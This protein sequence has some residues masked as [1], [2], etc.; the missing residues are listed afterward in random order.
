MTNSEIESTTQ[1]N[2]GG[3]FEFLPT[4]SEW[5]YICRHWGWWIA[6]I[7]TG[8][9]VAVVVLLLSVPHYSQTD[10][11]LVRTD[12]STGISIT[13][14]SGDA[15]DALQSYNLSRSGGNLYD[16][17]YVIQSR[18]LI[19]QVIDSL[20]L[21]TTQY[22][23]HG[24]TWR[25]AY[26]QQAPLHIV[27]DR[28]AREHNFKMKVTIVSGEK[29]IVEGKLTDG[30]KQTWT[31]EV[32]N[33]HEIETPA[34]RIA[35][36]LA[37]S[38]AKV[39]GKTVRVVHKTK[40][41]TATEFNNKITASTTSKDTYLI[42]ITCVDES[43]ERARDVVE[44]ILNA[45]VSDVLQSKNLQ[46][47]KMED[48]I[49]V[50]LDSLS[51]QLNVVEAELAIFRSNHQVI[52][53]EASKQAFF[54]QKTS[55]ESQQRELMQEQQSVSRLRDWFDLNSDIDVMIPMLDGMEQG[56]LLSVNSYNTLLEQ[57]VKIYQPEA[58]ALSS[59]IVKNLATELGA[60]RRSIEAS[61]RNSYLALELQINT[62]RRQQQ[63]IEEQLAA[64]PTGTARY[65]VLQQQ[66]KVLEGLYMYDLNL[67]EEVWLQLSIDVNNLRKIETGI[68]RE[69]GINTHRVG[70]LALGGALGLLII[71]IW[72]L[73][74]TRY[75]RY[76]KEANEV[77]QLTTLPIVG[78]LPL[79]GPDDLDPTNE[80]HHAQAAKEAF[81][82]LRSNI[83]FVRNKGKCILVTA[84]S[85]RQG[86]TF[87]SLNLAQT[88]AS[89]SH[90]V[91]L[92]DGDIRKKTA[93]K[94]ILEQVQGAGFTD[95]LAGSVSDISTI[96]HKE[97]DR[98]AQFDFIAGGNTAPNPSELMTLPTLGA[99]LDWARE[100][101]DYVIIDSAPA[102]SVAD[103]L[104]L[105]QHTDITLFIV[106]VRMESRR[107][108]QN[109]HLLA[110]Q[111]D[112]RNVNIV[113]NA[114]NTQETYYSS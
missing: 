42:N 24:L 20:D 66:Q 9:A 87:V 23:R 17:L 110:K 79:C 36:V 74:R 62:L 80:S 12:G 31:A 63:R 104:L 86:K 61:V 47:H 67:R 11:L 111:H 3:L 27:P 43:G 85:P 6:G 76:L 18:R 7:L 65:E 99:L 72:L 40:A 96:I 106:R 98:L 30:D 95:Y 45:Y 60:K 70:T 105:S 1:N 58:S 81:K 21:Q 113:I 52:A 59:P 101:Y 14:G 16:I 77:Q 19:E 54:Q 46:A 107:L 102:F 114:A 39:V 37:L 13:G 26:G 71:L 10:T 4:R 78:T 49:N 93:T 8:M 15:L 33:G 34:G 73:A 82:L 25:V 56:L 68:T 94:E 69:I 22:L 112:L 100:H 32:P 29:M 57:Y 84:S 83:D 88:I 91:L 108:L 64:N 44:A 53:H 89:T 92:L 97:A 50:R 109:L 41:E 28:K 35:F 103:T 38:D 48:Y 90:R 2:E 75:D 51:R 55:L 5:C